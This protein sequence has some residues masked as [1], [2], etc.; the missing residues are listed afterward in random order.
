MLAAAICVVLGG[1]AP[2]ARAAGE[3]PSPGCT[4]PAYSTDTPKPRALPAL[5]YGYLLHAVDFAGTWSARP[6][7]ALVNSSGDPFG[8]T[9][10]S[11]AVTERSIVFLRR[12]VHAPDWSGS[13]QV[14][15]LTDDGSAAAAFGLLRQRE[16]CQISPG[17]GRTVSDDRSDA[18]TGSVVIESRDPTRKPS[19]GTFRRSTWTVLARSGALVAELQ[20]AVTATPLELQSVD[21]GQVSRQLRDAVASR[22]LG[23]VP[24]QP[25]RVPVD[26]ARQ[27]PLPA[28]LLTAAELGSGWSREAQTFTGFAGGI[29]AFGRSG[30]CVY[31]VDISASAIRGSTL[32][33]PHDTKQAVASYQTVFTLFRGYGARYMALVRRNIALGC[34]QVQLAVPA[35]TLRGI[36]DDALLLTAAKGVSGE[37][38]L[39]VVRSGD[40]V[41]LVGLFGSAH[42]NTVAWKVRVAKRM[43]QRLGS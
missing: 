24:A 5:N 7:P 33:A 8:Q 38:A 25:L 19:T 41:S 15:R 10:V 39:I 16:L 32:H 36:G 31:D 20:L 30:R 26:A 6:E 18:Q 34:A 42:K 11:A 35:A 37:P 23:Q 17:L 28:T 3:I 21:V 9:S 29:D 1:A 40:Q 43:A 14:W 12:E 22:L 13:Q 2:N 4:P 27:P